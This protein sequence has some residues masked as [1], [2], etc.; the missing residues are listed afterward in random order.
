[1]ETH[2][3]EWAHYGRALAGMAMPGSKRTAAIGPCIWF[4]ILALG[5]GCGA[6]AKGPNA[7]FDP[8][9]IYNGVWVVH[10]LHP[11]SGASAGAVD[12]LKSRCQTFMLYFACEQTVNGKPQ[13]LIVYTIGTD[14]VRFNTRTIA[15]NGLAGGRGDLTIDGNRWTYLDKPPTGLTGPWSRVVNN[16]VDRNHIRFEEYESTDE[17]KHWTL[18]NRGSE[19]RIG[20][21]RA[22][23]NGKVGQSYL[24][25]RPSRGA[26]R[27]RFVF[28]RDVTGDIAGFS[29]HRSGHNLQHF[30]R[31]RVQAWHCETY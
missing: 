20:L 29:I 12:R 2:N 17:G 24:Q 31:R 5:F 13:A 25:P 15:P 26:P 3:A 6:C 28:A 14:S 9:T 30:T 27:V 19:D 4:C 22:G 11:W 1:M 10:A 23:L 16:I 7:P 21:G 8:L 18:T